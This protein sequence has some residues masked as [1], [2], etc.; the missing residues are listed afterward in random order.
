MIARLATPSPV[1]R[2][3]RWSW[4]LLGLA[5]LLTGY[6][7]EAGQDGVA[8]AAA[9]DTVAH[10]A[11]WLVLRTYGFGVLILSGLWLFLQGDEKEL[12]RK[13]L[14]TVLLPY[15]TAHLIGAVV[16]PAVAGELS[17]SFPNREIALTAAFLLAILHAGQHPRWLDVAAAS[18]CVGV[19]WA[20]L[21]SGR[22]LPSDVVAGAGMALLAFPLAL[23]ERA[24][25]GRVLA[26]GVLPAFRRYELFVMRYVAAA[27]F[28]WR[29]VAA[30]G[31]A[32]REGGRRPAVLDVGCGWGELGCFLRGAD[33]VPAFELHGIEFDPERAAVA[34]GRGY[35]VVAHDL[36]RGPLPYPPER[37]D[38]VVLSHVLEHLHAPARTLAAV[39]EV[40]RPGGLLIVG[41]PTKPPGTAWIARRAYERRLRQRGHQVGETCQFFT[42]RSLRALL[43]EAL[44][45]Y[46]VVD[47]R[48]FR[49]FS[50]RDSLPLEDWRWFWRVSS[51]LGRHLAAFTPEV[52]VVLRKRGSA[53][54]RQ[55]P[56]TGSHA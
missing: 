13:Y 24:R 14:P 42:L 55:P 52:N 23:R 47:V 27:D 45:G 30:G 40:L 2:V 26:F 7:L 9:R 34:T 12:A 32:T 36:E 28:L 44:P 49:L 5:A 46:A 15:A 43:A 22:G 25:H 10:A 20:V 17:Y 41:T 53:A 54:G 4:V 37:F 1:A 8:W 38:G 56:W 19:T 48:G 11:G 6:I 18:L 51:W 35:Q 33:A 31:G 39:D 16:H 21:A 29:D 3:P 50:A